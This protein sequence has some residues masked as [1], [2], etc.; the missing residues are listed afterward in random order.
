MFIR[1]PPLNLGLTGELLAQFNS[2]LVLKI[3]S[4]NLP[5]PE[6]EF[7]QEMHQYPIEIS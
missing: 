6:L 5:D 3:L 2:G 1:L 4:A 7:L